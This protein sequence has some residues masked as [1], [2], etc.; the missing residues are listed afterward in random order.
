MLNARRTVLRIR[1]LDA[2]EGGR[3]HCFQRESRMTST[4]RTVILETRPAGEEHQVVSARSDKKSYRKRPC[5]D[6]PWRV[7]ATREFPAEAFRHSAC[8]AYDM[9]E[10][11]FGCHQ[12]GT[13]KPA[14]CAGFLLRGADHNLAVRLRRM[15]GQCLDDVSDGGVVLHG[16]YV[17]M[18]V[19]N[20]VDPDDPCLHACR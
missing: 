15:S 6:C 11:V 2:V 5:S 13:D 4:Q 1:W 8:T 9:S 14:T 7:D 20:G 18:A 17:D 3:M 16:S 12:S 10:H 19:A